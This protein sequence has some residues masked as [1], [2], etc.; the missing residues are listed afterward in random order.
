MAI[1]TGFG[2]L[3]SKRIDPSGTRSTAV[4]LA[5]ESRGGP[6][7]PVPRPIAKLMLELRFIV[8]RWVIRG[9]LRR[10]SRA[11]SSLHSAIWCL[12]CRA[13]AA[14]VLQGDLAPLAH[15]ALPLIR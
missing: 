3:A 6:G 1:N 12:P 9:F 5:G 2:A 8:F 4:Q 10:C 11:C 15:M 7:D 13:R 14:S